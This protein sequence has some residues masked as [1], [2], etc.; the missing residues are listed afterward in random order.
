M[1]INRNNYETYFLLYIDNELCAADKKAVE[2]FVMQHIDLQ[3]ELDML[4]QAVLRPAL[5]AFEQKSS[6]LKREPGFQE[7]LL[8]YLD[9]ELDAADVAALQQALEADKNLQQEWSVLQQTKLQP[10]NETVF[11]H[12][13]ILMRKAPARIIPATWWRAAAVIIGFGLVGALLVISNKNNM[14]TGAV[15]AGEVATVR[16][17]KTNNLTQGAGT[18]TLQQADTTPQPDT[19]AQ[20]YAAT[21]KITNGQAV[22]GKGNTD[23]MANEQKPATTAK[24]NETKNENSNLPGSLENI[25]NTTSNETVT[26]SVPLT[27]NISQP[28]ATEL[29]KSNPTTGMA[30]PN[31][32]SAVKVN[33][34]LYASNTKN[35]ESAVNDYL[36]PTDKKFRRSG[37]IRQVSRFL[38][39]STKKKVDGDG[40]KIAGFEFAVR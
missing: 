24:K 15:G 22:T 6:L 36:T 29:I 27:E 21:A 14:Q 40:L 30:K 4:R 1:M 12:K 39:R 17:D 3:Q 38:K 2:A 25:N 8:L 26:V 16:S 35:D 28:A 13:E 20:P 33:N 32:E 18:S 10:S 7:K 9:G 31:P 19:K 34:A 5:V 11:A 23:A 37:L